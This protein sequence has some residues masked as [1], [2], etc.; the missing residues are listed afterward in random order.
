MAK[1]EK[2]LLREAGLKA[3]PARI[4]ALRYLH[5]LDEPITAENLH[6]ALASHGIDLS[7][8]YRTLNSFVS[9]G[10][11]RKEVG[12]HKENLYSLAT[13]EVQHLLVCLRCGKKVPLEGCPY[14]EVHE[15]IEEETGFHLLDHS[16]EIYGICPDC[17]RNG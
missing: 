14:H 5:S 10:I 1:D 2:T 9:S 13:E 8:L 4:E 3:T 17:Q 15:R 6:R 16:T 11:A 12:R 7:T